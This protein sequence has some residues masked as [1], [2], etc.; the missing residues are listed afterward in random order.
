V[1]LVHH[2]EYWLPALAGVPEPVEDGQ[3]Y[4]AGLL[5]VPEAAEVEHQRVGAPVD[6]RLHTDVAPRP[7]VPLGDAEVEDAT[8]QLLALRLLGGD[9]GL[10]HGRAVLGAELLVELTQSLELHGVDDRVQPEHRRPGGHVHLGEANV[11]WLP[12]LADG[13]V[14]P[15]VGTGEG[16]GRAGRLGQRVAQVHE[17]RVGVE[18]QQRQAGVQ[19]QLLQHH[20][21]GV[22][23]PGAALAAPERVAVETAAVEVER[24]AGLEVLAD[25]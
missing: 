25:G 22:G 23:L 17:I 9:Q 11:Q 8:Q 2:D 10:E 6:D 13:A 15:D 7:Q 12:A 20:A 18:H 24:L 16:R 5:G 1:G 3:G 4:C 14:D 21:Q 19:Q